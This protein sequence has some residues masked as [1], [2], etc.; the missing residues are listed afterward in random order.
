MTAPTSTDRIEKQMI[1]RAPRSRVWRALADSQQFGSWF[2]VKLE[3]PFVAGKLIKGSMTV[4][5]YEGMAFEIVVDELAPETRF[6]YRWHPFAIDPAVDYSGEPMTLVSFELEDVPEGTKLK[7]V[8]SG[9]DNIPV[10]RRAEALR[11]N[12]GGWEIQLENVSKHVAK[13]S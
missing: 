11:M 6:S 5:G 9:F 3:G 13:S 10:A 1:L 8:E 12:T 4:K 2:G 7:V